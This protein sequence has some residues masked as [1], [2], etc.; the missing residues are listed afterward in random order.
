MLL[1]C[2]TSD[3][4]LGYVISI[5]CLN[6]LH[7]RTRRDQRIEFLN[8]KKFNIECKIEAINSILKNFE[9]YNKI[10]RQDG[11][12]HIKCQ[13]KKNVHKSFII[14]QFEMLEQLKSFFLKKLDKLQIQKENIDS[15]L[16]VLKNNLD[17][18]N[19]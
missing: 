16:T 1:L 15:N 12:V 5:M 13:W 18:L 9:I 3:I 19:N 11:V 7:H 6:E 14:N 17:R 10:L 2:I 4:L 8:D